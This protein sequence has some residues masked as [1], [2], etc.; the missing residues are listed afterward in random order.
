MQ[1]YV[2]NYENDRV[3]LKMV[4]VGNDS[5]ETC[6]LFPYVDHQAQAG[7]LVKHQINLHRW[8]RYLKKNTVMDIRLHT[9][10]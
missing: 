5:K 8:G 4:E 10:T 7:F 3:V 9:V 6:I 2:Q 1:A